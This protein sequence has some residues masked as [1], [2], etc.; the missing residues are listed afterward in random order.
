MNK[1]EKM[2]E[3]RRKLEL[4][5]VKRKGE[6]AADEALK[7]LKPYF[8]K[9]DNMTTYQAIGRIRLVRLFL[10]SNLGEDDELFDCYCVLANL[11][12]GLEV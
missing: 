1:L 7:A 2:K 10:E 9:I 6:H 11:I 4:M 5:L 3:E 12:Q 8:E